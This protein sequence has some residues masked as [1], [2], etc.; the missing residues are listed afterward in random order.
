M[1]K[2]LLRA[3]LLWTSI[4]KKSVTVLHICCLLVFH[5]V[6]CIPVLLF[7]FH[8]SRWPPSSTLALLLGFFLPTVAKG[9]PIGN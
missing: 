2:G 8:H 4:I 7:F 3:V 5:P 9:L 6:Y 1:F